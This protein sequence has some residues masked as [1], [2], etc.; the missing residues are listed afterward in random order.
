MT[1][2]LLL[3]SMCFLTSSGT[4]FFV[5][6]HLAGLLGRDTINLYSSLR[7]RGITLKR[8]D[9]DM[10]N[11]LV[12]RGIAF[13]S[14]LTLVAVEE[15]EEFVTLAMAKI[16]VSLI[17][18]RLGFLFSNEH[19]ISFSD[20]RRSEKDKRKKTVVGTKWPVQKERVVCSRS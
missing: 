3:S 16:R 8:A 13:G 2:S 9:N 15:V 4:R 1:G 11:L 10:I 20:A 18:E 6:A 12:V 17:W 7:R 5:G 14:S 19:Y